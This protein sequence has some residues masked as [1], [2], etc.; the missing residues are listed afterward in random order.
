MKMMQSRRLHA[1]VVLVSIFYRPLHS[2]KDPMW[3]PMQD[4][5]N[6]SCSWRPLYS[7]EDTVHGKSQD[8]LWTSSLESSSHYPEDLMGSRRFS[9][10]LS[11]H[12]VFT[13]A[14]K[15][16]GKSKDLD[17][18]WSFFFYRG[19][20]TLTFTDCMHLT[21]NPLHFNKRDWAMQK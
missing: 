11:L 1:W 18:P 4:F 20:Y 3:S 2:P 9:H 16:H 10:W 12:R 7:P 6:A 5:T 13:L 8:F 17:F 15:S 14:R 19:L 21:D